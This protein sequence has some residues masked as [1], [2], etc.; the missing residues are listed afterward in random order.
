LWD[1]RIAGLPDCR[2]AG[3]LDWIED[4]SGNQITQLPNYPL[5]NYQIT[6][7]PDSSEA[8]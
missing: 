3:L 7:L 5:P 8:V 2:I 4:Q 6:Q 1:C